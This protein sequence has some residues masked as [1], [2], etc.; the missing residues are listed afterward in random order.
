MLRGNYIATID[1]KGRLKIPSFF[2]RRIE[3][4]Y[5]SEVYVT[6]LTG[7][8]VWIYPLQEWESVEQRLAVL[9]ALD[10]A[11]RAFLDRTNYFG[12]QT[13]IDA[14][15]RVLVPAVLRRASEL[16][17]EVTVFGQQHYL[18][19]WEAEKFQTHLRENPFTEEYEAALSRFI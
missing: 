8:S 18:E 15:G 3:D 5:G 1:D 9:P 11:K 10:R 13:A 14:Q 12:Q 19:V 4:K 17:G 7:E 2:R 6:S 16:L